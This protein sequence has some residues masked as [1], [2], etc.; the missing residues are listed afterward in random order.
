MLR[1]L[2]E[3]CLLRPRDLEPSRDDLEVAGV[4]N[5]GVIDAGSEVVVMG[6][7]D[8]RRDHGGLI[9]LNLRDRSGVVQVKVSPEVGEDIHNRAESVRSEYVLAV[10]GVVAKRPE[11]TEKNGL[12]TG[13]VY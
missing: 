6:W 10:R 9:F 7:V 4:F 3:T 8:T 12:P 1:R 5:P 11:G 13:G 2:F